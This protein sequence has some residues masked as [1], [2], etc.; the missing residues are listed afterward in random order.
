MEVKYA[1]RAH[2][3]YGGSGLEVPED[4]RLQVLKYLKFFEEEIIFQVAVTV[5]GE[6][7][8]LTRSG[9]K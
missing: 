4:P 1:Q 8:A 9:K 5:H 3:S 6:E 2:S 7:C